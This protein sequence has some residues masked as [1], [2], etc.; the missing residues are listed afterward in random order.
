MPDLPSPNQF[1]DM[2]KDTLRYMSMNYID[3]MEAGFKKGSPELKEATGEF[4]RPACGVYYKSPQYKADNSDNPAHKVCCV[5]FDFCSIYSQSWFY[6][7][8]GGAAFLL[9]LLVVAGIVG[10]LFLRKKKLG[11]KSPKE[12]LK[13]SKSTGGKKEGKKFFKGKSGSKDQSG[14]KK[15]GKK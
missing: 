11:S 3:L 4:F 15:G 2:A 5:M 14:Q 9:F 10:V 13:G 7:V 6:P 8:C 12:T 1:G